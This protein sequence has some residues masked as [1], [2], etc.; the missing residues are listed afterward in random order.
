MEESQDIECRGMN[1]QASCRCGW[2]IAG[3]SRL[4]LVLFLR[5][6]FDGG[7]A[8]ARSYFDPIRRSQSRRYWDRDGSKSKNGESSE[9]ERS[10][11]GCLLES[12]P[13][14]HCSSRLLDIRLVDQ[15]TANNGCQN[16]GLRFEL[17]QKGMLRRPE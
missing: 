8:A 13:V 2:R 5:R 17:A 1:F 7:R 6:L 4:L 3:I 11:R 9:E 10:V 16:L 15:P 14:F 12:C